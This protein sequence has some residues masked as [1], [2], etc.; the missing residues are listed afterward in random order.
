MERA[1]CIPTAKPCSVA[2]SASRVELEPVFPTTTTC[3]RGPEKRQTNKSPAAPAARQER[4]ASHP[5]PELVDRVGDQHDVLVPGH[6]LALS[7]RPANDDA[8]DAV[9][10]GSGSLSAGGGPRRTE[11]GT[12]R[13][14]SAPLLSADGHASGSARVKVHGGIS[15]FGVQAHRLGARLTWIWASRRRSYVRK[16]ILPSGRYGVLMAVMRAMFL[17]VS[18]MSSSGP[19]GLW[20]S[21]CIAFTRMTVLRGVEDAIRMGVSSA[22]PPEDAE[23][24]AEKRFRRYTGGPPRRR[25]AG[26]APGAGRVRGASECSVGKPKIDI[27]ARRGVAR[28]WDAWPRTRG[29]RA[30]VPPRRTSAPPSSPVHAAPFPLAASGA[31]R[32]SAALSWGTLRRGLELRALAEGPGRCEGARAVRY[33]CRGKTR[34]GDCGEALLAAPGGNPRRKTA[35][36]RGRKGHPRARRPP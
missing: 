20:L 26:P 19:S 23:R 29:A 9:L 33:R 16:S 10:R 25:C 24:P 35:A 4:A 7:G 17:I 36:S 14:F 27:C 6:Q 12:A 21:N 8:L 1:A 11:R 5:V 3:G 2:C 34:V 32:M 31:R 18:R 13:T 30:A 22:G 15:W 28:T